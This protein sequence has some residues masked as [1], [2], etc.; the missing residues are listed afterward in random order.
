[1]PL[2]TAIRVEGLDELRKAL[3]RGEDRLDK[4]LG[5]AGK[6]AA[7]IVAEAAK[8]KVPVRSGKAKS[9]LRSVVVRGGGGVRFGNA[10]VPYA[11]FL[12]YGNKVF[13]GN[14]VGRGDTVDRPFLSEG[15]IVYPTLAAKRAEV[16]DAYEELVRDVLRRADLS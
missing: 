16:R 3:R 6:K 5:K 14:K 11:G 8:S 2:D 9:S 4:E 1:M 12:D 13:Q 10:R 7:D 15:R